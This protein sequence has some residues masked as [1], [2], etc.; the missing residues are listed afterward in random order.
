MHEH[1]DRREFVRNIVVG[2]SAGALLNPAS[3][4]ADDPE[5][6]KPQEKAKD[7]DKPESDELPTEVDARM[8]IVLAR[9][10]KLLDAEARKAVRSEVASIVRR[11]EELR[12]VSLDN[13]DGPF[14]IFIPYRAPLA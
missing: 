7:A 3:A 6:P 1:T 13:G 2:A 14:P 4:R 12:K 10:G 5:K 11:A 9:F 8:A